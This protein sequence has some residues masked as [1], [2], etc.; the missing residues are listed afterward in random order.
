MAEQISR[1]SGVR[2]RS[3][4]GR[5]WRRARG[6]RM[7][8]VGVDLR[9]ME[10]GGANGGVKPLVFSFLGE[11]ARAHGKRF[12]FVFFANPELVGELA[13]IAR[14]EDEI[15]TSG[16]AA[17]A[18]DVLYAPFGRSE[19]MRP[20]VPT[21]SLVVDLLHRDLPSALPVEEVNYR[22]AW[23]TQIARDAAYFQCISHYTAGRLQHH[24]GV[25]PR[26]CF[27][28]H[29]AVQARLGGTTDDAAAKAELARAGALSPAPA[30]EC[31]FFFPANSWPHK[32][33]E[34]LFEA[35]RRYRADAKESA[36][37]LVLTGHPDERMR[38]LEARA[39]AM[40]LGAAVRFSGHLD[41]E[42]FVATWRGAG[43]LVYPSLHEGFGIPLLEAMAFG[44]PILAA[45]TTSLPE[46]GGDVCVYVDPRNV[47][48]M[49]AAMAELAGNAALRADLGRRGARRL[50]MFSL[51][52]EAEK[53]AEH[54]ARAG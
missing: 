9:L 45:N 49:A 4:L 33:H 17:G 34:A 38:A 7:V 24:Y 26:R 28:T 16:G 35:F 51:T 39:G 11:I 27:V 48:A 30:A 19:L 53:L 21:V 12:R 15:V 2:Q 10:P 1:D 43:V 20:E 47:A 46:V 50:K 42:R 6:G 31:Y 29:V 14:G 22:H 41:H 54:L 52:R 25:D 8:A 32:N 5:W 13:D 37:S 44:V 36:W 18:F 40:G 23:F 3:W